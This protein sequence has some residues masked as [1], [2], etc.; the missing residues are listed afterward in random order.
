[1]LSDRGPSDPGFGLLGCAAKHPYSTEV[2]RVHPVHPAGYTGF[3]APLRMTMQ[4]YGMVFGTGLAV[5]F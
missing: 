3:L 5:G 1:M 4:A 2:D